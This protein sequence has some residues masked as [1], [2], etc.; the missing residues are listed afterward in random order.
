MATNAFQ[1]SFRVP[2]SPAAAAAAACCSL[3]LLAP[4]P[5]PPLPP[6]WRSSCVCDFF[7]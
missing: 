2:S 1:S 5:I 4:L 3:L 7:I 6:R